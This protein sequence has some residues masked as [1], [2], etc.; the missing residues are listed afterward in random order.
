MFFSEDFIAEVEENPVIG[1]VKACNLTFDELSNLMTDENS[2]NESEHELLWEAA[3]FISIVLKEEGI[4]L[5][6]N[7]PEPTGD[8][9]SN[10]KATH[11]YMQAVKKHFEEKSVLL[12]VQAYT[13]R[14][15]SALRSSFAYEF[16][17]GDL[18]RIQI[19]INE[20]RLNIG[21]NNT[22][23]DGHKRRLLRRLENLQSELHK[24]VSDLDRFWGLVGDAGVV[25]G[26]LG[27]DA[28]PIVDRTRELAEIVW[29]TQ[30]RSEELPSDMENPM[31][32]HKND[33]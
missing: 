17:Q 16:S 10:S 13:G 12:K 19:L 26:K 1:I 20:L 28:K 31:L 8:I 25:L 4:D 7:F 11:E 23:D 18:E 6:F 29:K 2:W 21:E 9:Q 24:R 15:K 27:K 14:Y 5:P 33:S 22:L 3:S 30:A 32:E